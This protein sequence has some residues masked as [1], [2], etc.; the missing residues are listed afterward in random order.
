M[1]ISNADL[2]SITDTCELENFVRKYRLR[3]GAGHV[4]CMDDNRLPKKVLFGEI[5][6]GA[7]N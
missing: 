2:Y 3:W 5:K 7:L 1:D 4:R 6:G